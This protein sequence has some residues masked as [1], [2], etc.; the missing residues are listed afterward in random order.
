MSETEKQR[1]RVARSSWVIPSLPAWLLSV[2]FITFL[3]AGT[4]YFVN[5]I[6]DIGEFQ[7]NMEKTHKELFDA[8]AEVRKDLKQL[9]MDSSKR[10]DDGDARLQVHMESIDSKLATLLFFYC[11]APGPTRCTP[12]GRPKQ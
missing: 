2:S 4:A 8:V 6:R 7:R 12:D 11:T 3:I 5:A 9:G 10:T 1:D